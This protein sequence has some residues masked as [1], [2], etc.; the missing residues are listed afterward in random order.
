VIAAIARL[1]VTQGAPSV[2]LIDL[3]QIAGPTITLPAFVL[4]TSGLLISGIAVGLT[5]IER[6]REAI[7][8]LIA[9]A[10]SGT[11]RIETEPV[12]LA[13]IETAWQQQTP[14]NRRLVVLP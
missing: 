5:T 4:R 2:R 11:L 9:E 13:Q 6:L 8:Q 10:A 14:D 7:P 12:P 3:G 1:D